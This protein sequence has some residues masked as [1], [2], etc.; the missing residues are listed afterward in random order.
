MKI[1]DILAQDK[2]VLS[3]EVFPPKEEAAF[4]PVKAAAFEIAKLSPAF[5]S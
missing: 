3:L 1:K 2:P 5:M 4:E